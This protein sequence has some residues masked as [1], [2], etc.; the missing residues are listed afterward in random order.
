M[1][2][3]HNNITFSDIVDTLIAFMD[4]KGGEG[5]K[6]GLLVCENGKSGTSDSED[7]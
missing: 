5:E 7:S 6:R 3:I 4:W 1:W 2:N